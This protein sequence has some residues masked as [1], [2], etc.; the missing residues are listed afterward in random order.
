M[1]WKNHENDPTEQMRRHLLAS[2][3]T[4]SLLKKQ[5]KQEVKEKYAL[6]KRIKELREELDGR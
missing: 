3:E 5:I 6:Y 1:A 2:E 4:V